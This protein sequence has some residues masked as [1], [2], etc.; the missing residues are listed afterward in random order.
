VRDVVPYPPESGD[1]I[2][3]RDV[4]RIR[5]ALVRVFGEVSVAEDIESMVDRDDGYIP[6]TRQVVTIVR[7][8]S[9][10]L[11]DEGAAVKI[12][13]HRK[14]RMLPA[15]PGSPD[16]EGQ[17]ILAGNLRILPELIQMNV[18]LRTWVPDGQGI[19]DPLPWRGKFGRKKAIGSA[20]VC[21]I[22]HA[23]EDPDTIFRHSS[24]DLAVGCPNDRK[25]I[26]ACGGQ[27]SRMESC[28]GGN[29]RI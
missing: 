22:R 15:K 23:F 10:L 20:R 8:G 14:G 21:A 9:R 2:K 25:L 28:E 1:E 24:S 4:A 29:A 12:H 5:K 26:V 19:S 7:R 18:K 6:L 16:V 27:T 13:H 11:S 17:A 3:L